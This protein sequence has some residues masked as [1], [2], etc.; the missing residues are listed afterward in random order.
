M[1]G[2][3]TGTHCETI[4]YKQNDSCAVCRKPHI[5]RL[6]GSVHAATQCPLLPSITLQQLIACIENE[7]GLQRASVSKGGAVL[8][9]TTLHKEYQANLHK[10]L[11]EL[12]ITSGD[13]LTVNAS[14][15]SGKV[16][17]LF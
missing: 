17:M 2:Q 10:S 8:Y 9:L 6:D 7:L 16:L 15:K 5:L 1:G 4:Q 11:N 14:G 3:Q 13:T 12:R